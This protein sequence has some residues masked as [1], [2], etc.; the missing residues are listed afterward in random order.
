MNNQPGGGQPS[1]EGKDYLDKADASGRV[2]VALDAAEKKFGKGKIDPNKSRGIN[3]KI[4]DFARTTF[5][6]M[7]GK[8]VPK[9]FSN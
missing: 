6:K 4:T 9:K 5:E 2:D 7:T 3:E 8:K 1:G